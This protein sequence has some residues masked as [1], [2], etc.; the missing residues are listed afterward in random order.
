MHEYSSAQP[1]YICLEV[2]L[3]PDFIS[4]N[5]NHLEYSLYSDPIHLSIFVAQQWHWQQRTVTQRSFSFQINKCQI[6]HEF[7]K[8]FSHFSPEILWSAHYEM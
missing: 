3:L 5:L 4:K 7:L 8:G 1:L 2:H 6:K